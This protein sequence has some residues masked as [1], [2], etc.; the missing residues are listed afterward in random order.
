MTTLAAIR[1]KRWQTLTN[2]I[3]TLV[4]SAAITVNFARLEDLIAANLSRT[5]VRRQTSTVITA[6]S[7][8]TNRVF[9]TEIEFSHLSALIDITALAVSLK[10][11]P[12]WTDA[13]AESARQ[14]TSLVLWTRL[15]G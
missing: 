9:A 12:L 4:I 3:D 6:G 7:V 15:G 2:L 13:G 11:E 1:D 14:N 8:D 5:R 10:S